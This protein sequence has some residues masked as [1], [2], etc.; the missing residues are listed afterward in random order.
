MA[1]DPEPRE[2]YSRLTC[3]KNRIISKCKEGAKN[4]REGQGN[5]VYGALGAWQAVRWHVRGVAPFN[6]PHIQTY[7]S[8]LSTA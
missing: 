3:F 5:S 8:P 4:R 6:R 2:S 7:E 1:S